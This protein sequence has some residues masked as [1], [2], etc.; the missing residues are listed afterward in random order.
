MK[1]DQ[2]EYRDN[3][4]LYQVV[5]R[6]NELIDKLTFLIDSRARESDIK[7]IRKLIKNNIDFAMPGFNYRQKDKIQK[8]RDDNKF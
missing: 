5:G 6:I 3:K 4:Y 8:W 7:P 2:M 1:L